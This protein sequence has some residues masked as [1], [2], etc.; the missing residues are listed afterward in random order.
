MDFLTALGKGDDEESIDP[1][2]AD[3]GEKILACNPVLEGFGNSKTVRNNNS[4]R[5]GKYVLMYFALYENRVFG[6]RIKN[7]LLE[8]SRVVKVAPMERSY[9]VFYFLLKGAPDEMLRSLFLIKTD[10]SRY[11]WKDFRYLKTGGDLADSHD[12]EGFEEIME[13][14]QALQFTEAH[15]DAIWRMVAAILHL[16]EIDFVQ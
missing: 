10:G 3:I 16:G 11:E 6:A 2:A 9:H 4:S 13:T 12:V 7:Y 5:F 8:K 14:L 1:E 15:I